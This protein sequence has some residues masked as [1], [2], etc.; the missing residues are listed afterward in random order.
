MEPGNNLQG[1]K[2]TII[3]SGVSGKGLASFAAGLGA[4]VFVTERKH[5]DEEARAMFRKKGIA[6]EEDGSEYTIEKGAPYKLVVGQT[7]PG[8][9]NKPQWVSNIDVI[10]AE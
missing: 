9:V 2:I 5:L 7:E 8:D 1:K 6:W 10:I 3:G 4:S